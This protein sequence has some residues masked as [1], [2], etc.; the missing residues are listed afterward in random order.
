MEL[1]CGPMSLLLGKRSLGLS[2]GLST[3][4]LA[5]LQSYYP[6]VQ[7]FSCILSSALEGLA[8]MYEELNNPPLPEHISWHPRQWLET[9]FIQQAHLSRL[10]SIPT[11]DKISATVHT[12]L[13]VHC[14]CLKLTLP[15]THPCQNWN[16]SW[17]VHLFK[18]NALFQCIFQAICRKAERCFFSFFYKSYYLPYGMLWLI[19]DVI[20]VFCKSEITP[21]GICTDSV[22]S[23]WFHCSG[24][25]GHH[26]RHSHKNL[27]KTHGTSLCCMDRKSYNPLLGPFLAIPQS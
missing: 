20:S 6:P 14:W 1:C 2:E 16:K 17:C 4:R 5:C 21:S 24:G 18:I 22:N 15:I 25:E 3:K 11:W 23:L 26:H 19:Q 10:I 7:Q 27:N 13:N 8:W 9:S 12:D